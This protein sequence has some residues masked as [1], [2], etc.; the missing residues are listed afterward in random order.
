MKPIFCLTL[1]L[2]FV[3]TACATPNAQD[4][5]V[6]SNSANSEATQPTTEAARIVALTSLTADI[7]QQLDV[8]KLVGIPGNPLLS[9]DSRFKGI[10]TVS[11]GRTEP[12]LEKIVALEPDLVI[13]ASGFHDQAAQ[14][15][16]ELGISTQLTDVDSLASLEELTIAL[17]ATINADPQP[18]LQ[19][20][21]NCVAQSPTEGPSTLVLVSRQPI[22]S[23]NQ[24]SW[25]GDLLSK[26]NIR[27]LTAEL[28]Q[29]SAAEMPGQ[30]AFRG[31]ITL[32]AE[33]I[34]EADPEVLI[35]VDTGES[36]LEQFQSDPFWRQLQAVEGDRVYVF[37]YYG[38]VN[39]GSIDSI[40][41][42][43]AQ[44]NQIINN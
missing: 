2:S 24:E 37:D 17:A 16:E 29:E 44:L 6:R 19:Q 40:E 4:P 13:G 25:A 11:S 15:L 33:K 42:A 18:L 43:C 22:L 10:E 23:P 31:Y 27:N 39:P 21:E 7:L 36:I 20:Y 38:L 26:F 12:N 35:V 32:S 14:R 1:C 30:T 41:Q 28:Q 3:F 5:D 8:E 34:V 9:A